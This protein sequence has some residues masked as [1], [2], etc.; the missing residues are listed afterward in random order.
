MSKKG[1]TK[2]VTKPP[3]IKPISAGRRQPLVVIDNDKDS[4]SIFAHVII[5]YDNQL[6]KGLYIRLISNWVDCCSNSKVY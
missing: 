4:I 3:A 5:D 6:Y 2:P 1:T